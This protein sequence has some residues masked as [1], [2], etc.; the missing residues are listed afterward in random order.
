MDEAN[1]PYTTIP[2]TKTGNRRERWIFSAYAPPP[3]HKVTSANF[4]K[5]LMQVK[6]RGRA[7]VNQVLCLRNF[8]ERII[9]V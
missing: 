7:T 8:R 9:L 2:K 3:F 5:S 6:E 1:V 4:A